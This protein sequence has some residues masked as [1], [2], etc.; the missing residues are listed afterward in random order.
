MAN[1]HQILCV[2]VCVW[3]WHCC[4]VTTVTTH[5]HTDTLCCGHYYIYTCIWQLHLLLTP[6]WVYIHFSVRIHTLCDESA[7]TEN[8]CIEIEFVFFLTDKKCHSLPHLL[9]LFTML[10]SFWSFYNYYYLSSFRVSSRLIQAQRSITCQPLKAG[11]TCSRS[12]TV[13]RRDLT[14]YARQ[15][16]KC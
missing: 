14:I 3:E 10:P 11:I 8:K 16:L 15:I 4:A 9:S 2:C 12:Q 6:W 13:P 7:G 5:T 1:T